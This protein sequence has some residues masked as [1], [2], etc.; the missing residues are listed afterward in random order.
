VTLLKYT[1]TLCALR[2]LFVSRIVRKVYFYAVR[3]RYSGLEIR[4]TPARTEVIVHATKTSA[5]LG[6]NGRRIRELTALVAKRFGYPDG[7]IEVIACL[8]AGF[9][10]I[11]FV[12]NWLLTQAPQLKHLSN[13]LSDL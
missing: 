10:N 3:C 1:P 12:P 2:S 4:A 6:E 7:S 13:V 11:F 9:I 5:V 8:I